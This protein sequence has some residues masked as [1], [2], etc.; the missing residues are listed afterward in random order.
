[1]VSTHLTYEADSCK[2]LVSIFA[3]FADFRCL[4]SNSDTQGN[5]LSACLSCVA[6]CRLQ[7]MVDLGILTHL[8]SLPHSSEHAPGYPQCEHRKM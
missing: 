5:F 6:T 4:D 7:Q 1:M 2:I 8:T 3:V